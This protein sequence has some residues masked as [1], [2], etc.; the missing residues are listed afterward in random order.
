MGGNAAFVASPKVC[1][2][3]P[4][5]DTPEI[6]NCPV[7]LTTEEKVIGQSQ[8]LGM[9]QRHWHDSTTLHEQTRNK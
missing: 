8:P 7:T 1:S 6:R 2:T 9:S 3:W 5:T 4:H